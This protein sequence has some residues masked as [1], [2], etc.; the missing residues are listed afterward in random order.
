MSHNHPI[1]G[2]GITPAYLTGLIS[3]IYPG[4]KI[5]HVDIVTAKTYG[6]EM[7]STAGRAIIDV[8]YA[9]GSAPDLPT[10]LVIK[11][12]RDEDTFI[13][14]LYENEVAFYRRIRPELKVEAPRCFG[15]DFNEE[16]SRFAILFE[17]LTKRGAR[18]PNVIQTITL[19]NVRAILDTVAA[20]HAQY[21]ETPRFGGDLSW[22]G[23]H[24]TGR[25]ATM[26]NEFVPAVIQQEIDSTHFK[27]EMVQRLRT[28][29]E[30]LRAGLY[31]VQRHQANLP[32]TLLH[33]DTHIGN[34]Y[35]LP[36]GHAG[37][38]DWQLMVRGHAMHDV[39]YL[40]TTS[41]SI[42]DRRAHERE[43]LAYYLDRLA[44]NGVKTPPSSEDAWTEYRR[45]LIWGVYIG[46]L[47]TPVVNYGWEINIMNHLRLTTAFEDL[48]TATLVAEVS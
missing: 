33:G 7:V 41:L 13:S 10:R 21:W 40:I 43:L 24:L 8:R 48:D 25:L 42:G 23:T 27:R 31:A 18:F 46:W 14:P 45:T 12:P 32:Q 17:D 28:T 38:L 19:E 2:K 22:L 34:T 26:M 16:T 3:E 29:G 44:A 6:E 5:E 20:L 15:A 9:A 36:D 30:E 47:T 37:L 4:T 39:N 1:D 35:L 11:I